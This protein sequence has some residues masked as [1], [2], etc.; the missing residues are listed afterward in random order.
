MSSKNT[1]KGQDATHMFFEKGWVYFWI[2]RCIVSYIDVI[3]LSTFSN[4]LWEKMDMKLKIFTAFYPQI[5]GK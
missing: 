5:D 3:F 1:I 4:A 2:L